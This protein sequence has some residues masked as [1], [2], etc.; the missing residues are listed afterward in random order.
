MLSPL[1]HLMYLLCELLQQDKIFYR[2]PPRIALSSPWVSSGSKITLLVHID[3][4]STV[5]FPSAEMIN[6]TLL[7]SV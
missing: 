3:C 6:K 4:L 1:T 7:V 2:V 5:T